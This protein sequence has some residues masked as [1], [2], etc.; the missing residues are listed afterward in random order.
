M[1]RGMRDKKQPPQKG[2]YTTQSNGNVSNNQ[3]QIKK[4]Y[5]PLDEERWVE[6]DTETQRR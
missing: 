1:I 2:R 6:L 5:E 3:P 4:V